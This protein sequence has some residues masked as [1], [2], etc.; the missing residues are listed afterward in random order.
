MAD[1]VDIP[2][3]LVPYLKLLVE[4]GYAVNDTEALTDLLEVGF[5]H[6]GDELS[7]EQPSAGMRQ[8]VSK[9][10]ETS[11]RAYQLDRW[12]I[13]EGQLSAI[14]EWLGLQTDKALSLAAFIGFYTEGHYFLKYEVV[15]Y[16]ACAKY[17]KMVDLLPHAGHWHRGSHHLER[18][19]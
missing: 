13:G 7:H 11:L 6:L 5:H 17:R 2:D 4:K 15:D 14:S 3:L 1:R 9:L 8:L 19:E 18:V 16:I 12:I 10:Q